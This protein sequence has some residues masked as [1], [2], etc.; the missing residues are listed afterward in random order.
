MSTSAT[1]RLGLR[2]AVRVPMAISSILWRRMAATSAASALAGPISAGERI[3]RHFSDR[4]RWHL[5][6]LY[7]RRRLMRM[8]GSASV[9]RA[10]DEAIAGPEIAGKS[11]SPRHGRRAGSLSRSVY[12]VS[13]SPTRQHQPARPLRSH[14][15]RACRPDAPMQPATIP[16][17]A[18]VSG[19][20]AISMVRNSPAPQDHSR[21]VARDGDHF[22]YGQMVA[23]LGPGLFLSPCHFGRITLACM[24]SAAW[25]ADR[26]LSDSSRP[27]CRG[28]RPVDLMSGTA[29]VT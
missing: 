15:C 16:P 24:N 27:E 10:H 9:S 14:R 28:H 5:D 18:P 25:P 4:C 19:S 8:P 22:T 11:R 7:G 1:N 6:G 3:E 29:S 26:R 17:P 2:L 21:L 13:D 20:G 12:I 23:E